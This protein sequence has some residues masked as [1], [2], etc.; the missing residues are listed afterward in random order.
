MTTK[1]LTRHGLV[2]G[3][4]SSWMTFEQVAAQWW[5]DGKVVHE[6]FYYNV[7]SKV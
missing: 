2:W 6:L 4:R 7:L 5:E 3:S 1:F